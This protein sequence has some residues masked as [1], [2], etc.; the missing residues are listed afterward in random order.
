M[1]D[2]PLVGDQ[3]LLAA[4]V[5]FHNAGLHDRGRRSP[6]LGPAR[7]ARP[8]EVGHTDP[9]GVY[10][11]EVQAGRS[12]IWIRPSFAASVRIS[13]CSGETSNV[14]TGTTCG[15]PSGSSWYAWPAAS[16][17]MFCRIGLGLGGAV[18]TAIERH[19]NVYA[20]PRPHK[21]GDA[22]HLIHP[23]AEGPHALRDHS[24]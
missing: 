14:M 5:D 12:A 15:F 10:F 1:H 3:R 4:L 6:H 23:Y 24:C 21:A 19:Q 18:P 16:A 2:G 13:A 9:L 20:R 17:W 8:E 7:G 11:F 22:N